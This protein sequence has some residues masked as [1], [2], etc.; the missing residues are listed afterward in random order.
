MALYFA[1]KFGYDEP[2]PARNPNMKVKN[3]VYENKREKKLNN[4]NK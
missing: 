4:I 3:T 2:R 1:Q